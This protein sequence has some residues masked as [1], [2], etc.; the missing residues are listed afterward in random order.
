MGAQ[1]LVSRRAFL[2]RLALAG[3]GPLAASW[4]LHRVFAQGSA[5]AVVT[6]TAKRPA[7]PSGV[8]S[9]DVTSHAAHNLQGAKVYGVELSPEV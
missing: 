6:P 3:A 1:A 8:A 5:P 2:S 4:P 9:G 7:M